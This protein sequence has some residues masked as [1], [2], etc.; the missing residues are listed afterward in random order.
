MQTEAMHDVVIMGGGLAGLCLALQLNDRF[1]DLRIRVLERRP[2]PLPPAAHKVGES[3]VEIGAHYFG[4]VLRLREY[5]DK[6]HIHKF[7]FRFFFSEFRS[8]LP[9][10]TEL[11]VREVLPTPT[12]QIDRGTFETH[13]GEEVRRRGIEFLDSTV[14]RGFDLA[15]G[16]G[17]HTV[18][19]EHAGQSHVVQSRW[20]IDAAGR[21]S[22]IKRKQ[23]LAEANGHDA[24]AVWFRIDDKL[25]IDVWCNDEDWRLQC[26][27]P[28]RWRSTNHLCGPGY[29]VWLI[30]L[31]SGAHSVGI[32]CD[33]KMHPLE[34]MNT[35]E[36]AMEWLKKFQP[37]VWRECESRREKLMDFLFL[38][39]F[40]HGCKQV[41]SGDRWA[42]TGEAGVF[43]DPFYS[44]GSDFIAISNTYIC[45]LIAHDR[46][47]TPVAPYA[48]I[49]EQLYFSFYESTLSLYRDQYPLFGDAEV[50]PVKVIW[51][52][53]YYWGVLCQIV[54]Q[55]R[56]TD[57][58]LF[59][60][61][62]AE[63]ER[64]RA[65]NLRMQTFF[66]EW[67]AASPNRN[68]AQFLDQGE[69]DWFHELNR[70]LHEKL[71]EDELRVRLRDCVA[72]LDALAANIVAQAVRAA[73]ELGQTAPVIAT[74]TPSSIAPNLFEA[75]A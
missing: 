27:P 53:A 47:G 44:P 13:I 63:F 34:T 31:G 39:G 18:R 6:D 14:V 52:Y 36:R 71:G 15:Q 2:H 22:L 58:R 32:V 70:T 67:M 21:A 68:P 54:F 65:L 57:L 75:A 9:N 45:E 46:A 35:F 19:Y 4:N 25:E 42:I 56:L 16:D 73:P 28:E 29:W 40:S 11:G 5:L 59:G 23:G 1:P 55:D 26:T 66:R 10:V 51:D 37:I 12:F 64:A 30:P 24:N 7:G 17:P 41:F 43:L 33:A 38:R 60:E 49:Y 72:M 3:T 62:R 50:M 20:L 69:L 8:D 61:L 74:D 48:K